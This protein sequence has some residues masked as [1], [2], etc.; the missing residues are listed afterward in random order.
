MGVAL[1]LALCLLALGIAVGFGLGY[2]V[3]MRD[4]KRN[5]DGCERNG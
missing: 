4:L 5:C 1:M 2:E 3:C